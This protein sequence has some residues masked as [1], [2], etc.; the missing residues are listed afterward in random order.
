M[1]EYFSY[2]LL[3]MVSSAAAIPLKY[4]TIRAAKHTCTVD[5][6]NG[7]LARMEALLG[8][9]ALLARRRR[10]EAVTER[11]PFVRA[12]AAELLPEAHLH[13]GVS[14]R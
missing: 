7:G 13:V 1:L 11:V 8:R 6:E 4:V 9:G 14:P 2:R 3:N 10:L 12:D 5:E